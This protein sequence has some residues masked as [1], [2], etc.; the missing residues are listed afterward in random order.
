MGNSFGSNLNSNDPFA[1]IE[2]GYG[3]QPTLSQIN[4]NLNS[5][6]GQPPKVLTPTSFGIFEGGFNEVKPK[7]LAAPK[8]NF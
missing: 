4:L 1:E 8:N 6:L 3:I 2:M 7:N 5:G